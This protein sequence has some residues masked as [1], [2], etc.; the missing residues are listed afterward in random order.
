MKKNIGR[1]QTELKDQELKDKNS[2]IQEL[3][4]K[5]FAL[6]GTAEQNKQQEEETKKSFWKKIFG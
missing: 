6:L 4:T 5:A 3:N 2:Y 1:K